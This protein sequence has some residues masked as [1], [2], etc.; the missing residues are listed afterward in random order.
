VAAALITG[1]G[2]LLGTAVLQAWD[3]DG[4]EPVALDRGRSDL[5]RPGDPTRAV[6]AV[7]PEV[8]V[9]LA[10]CASGTPGYRHSPL[11]DRWAAASTELATACRATGAQFV[12]T[13]TV[14]DR[15][16]PADAYSAAKAALR[17]ALL[18]A[19]RAGEA[20]W[21]RPFYVVDEVA[22][23]PEVVAAALE[24]CDDGRP[25]V[26]RTPGS[27]HDFVCAADV[28]RAVVTAV[29]AGLRG[30]VDVGTGRV[31]PVSALVEA[32]GVRWE[33]APDPPPA[34]PRGHEPADP[35]VLRA[36]GWTPTTTEE[37][38]SRG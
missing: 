21:L 30:E 28:G 18:P 34:D 38:F 23:R 7:R 1:A 25:V 4:L 5:L 16:A 27:A 17:R 36:Q 2:G 13:G 8:V 22:R 26:L 12:G 11:N 9:H 10:W 37:L 6:A 20:T 33:A 15:G 31:R 29:R 19:L 3:V 32:L 35:A 24:A 14:L